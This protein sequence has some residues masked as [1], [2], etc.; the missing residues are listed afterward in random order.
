MRGQNQIPWFNRQTGLLIGGAIGITFSTIGLLINYY[1]NESLLNQKE[2]E[3]CQKLLT[4]L[5]Y[6]G[7]VALISLGK[8]IQPLHYATSVGLLVGF[9]NEVVNE[10]PNRRR[11]EGEPQAIPYH[12]SLYFTRP[13][14]A[15]FH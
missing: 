15:W 11:P 2:Q 14:I 9:F 8:I 1:Q 7:C 5:P 4:D 13:E 10:E 6:I 3:I 12:A